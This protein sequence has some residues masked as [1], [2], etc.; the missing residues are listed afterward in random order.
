[1]V[2]CFIDELA[3]AAKKDPVEYRRGLLTG[4]PR[5]LRALNLAAEKFGWGKPLAAGRAAGV[6]VH[7]S[8]GSFVCHISEVSVEKNQIRVHRVVSAIDCGPI[9]NPDTVEAQIQSGI[10]YGLTAALK[11]GITL[12]NGLVDQVNFGDFR[13]LRFDEMPAVEVHIADS[14]DPMGGVGEPGVPPIAP[15][16][17]NAVF[18]LTGKRLR[19]LPLRLG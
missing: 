14:K 13:L 3:A 12:T 4:H 17:A 8:F 5:H 2:E 7:E 18:A 6:A 1:V 16:V 19:S 9:V 15:A 11:S 10:V